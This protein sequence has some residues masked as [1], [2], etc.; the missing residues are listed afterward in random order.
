M[1]NAPSRSTCPSTGASEWGA[2]IKC[3]GSLVTP[4]G[5][6]TSVGAQN[7]PQNGARNLTR[8]QGYRQEQAAQRH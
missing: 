7:S 1:F 5:I 6:P 3:V 4:N 8:L 2:S